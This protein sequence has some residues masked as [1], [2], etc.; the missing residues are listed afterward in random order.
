MKL[1]LFEEGYGQDGNAF[2]AEAEKQ[3]GELQ[4]KESVERGME[5]SRRKEN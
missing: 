4:T 5:R 2:L 1:F 3:S